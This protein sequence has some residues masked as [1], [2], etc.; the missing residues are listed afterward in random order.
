MGARTDV[1]V[2]KSVCSAVLQTIVYERAPVHWPDSGFPSVESLILLPLTHGAAG[3]PT[4]DSSGG[5]AAEAAAAGAGD[6]VTAAA[7][8]AGGGAIATAWAPSSS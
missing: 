3:G 8:G 2:R 5:M 1:L 7:A 6:G 4:E